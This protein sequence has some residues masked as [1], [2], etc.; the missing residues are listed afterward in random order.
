MRRKNLGDGAGAALLIGLNAL[1]EGDV[2][3]RVIAGFVHVLQAEEIG[4]ALG[5]AAELQISDGN[6]KVEALIDA[7]AGPAAG[8]EKD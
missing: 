6:G 4:F 7:V 2:R 1:E 3:V 8:A 5:V